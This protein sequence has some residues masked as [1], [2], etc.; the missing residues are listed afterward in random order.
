MVGEA[1]GREAT[2][3]REQASGERVV[4]VS[5]NFNIIHPGHLRLLN[6]A[7]TC[8]DRLVVGLFDDGQPGVALPFEVR[9]EALESLGAVGHVVSL[10]NAEL[11]AFIQT[12]QPHAVVKG[13]EHETADNPEREAVRTYGG[14][15]IF[16]AGEA[17]FSAADLL[18][19]EMALPAEAH[20]RHV[21]SFLAKHG[22]SLARLA[23]LAR[24]FDGR[25][26]LVLGD[27]IID[28]YISCDPLGMSQ[29]DPTIVVT[30][31]ESRVFTGGAGIVAGHVAGLGA[32]ASF[33][34]I[35]GD[36]DTATRSEA[37][38]AAYG[39]RAALIRDG[40]RPTILKQRY[41]AA[42]KTLLRVSHLRSHDAGEEFVASVLER[43]DALLPNTDL[44]IFSDFNY[45]CL[46]QTL[47]EAVAARCRAADVPYVA[48]SQASSQVG[49]VSRYAGAAL[50]SATEREVRLAVH[51]FKSGLQNVANKLL[52]KSGAQMLLVK[53]GAE[54][55]LVL[56]P[57][58]E[59]ATGSLP[60][61]NSN[62]VDVAGA[63]DA[64]LAA[65][66]LALACGASIWECAYVGSVAA[67]IQ[68]SRVGNVPLER[69]ALLR[70]LRG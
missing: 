64:L 58:P 33:I 14:H 7:R 59:F 42:N 54:G 15:L 47:V 25:R 16:S 49:D 34:S 6:F 12:L 36:D 13:K 50:I 51:D 28:E 44:M 62:P 24:A 2:A 69:D 1:L 68:V 65:A 52:E 38:L 61:M 8:G 26:V 5:G 63:G 70:E 39:V 31:V 30:P 56:Q 66:G 27:L 17:R 67:A 45:G 11:T 4:F 41:R 35:T 57:G 32:D 10:T 23:E 22:S 60:A 3:L 29:E 40:S 21:P 37:A 19:R 20:V 9:R 48:D 43:V 53:L 18:R 46:P 55:M